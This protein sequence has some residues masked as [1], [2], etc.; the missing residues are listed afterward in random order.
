M[1]AKDQTPCKSMVDDGSPFAN[2]WKGS[3]AVLVVEDIEL[4]VHTQ[5][6]SL[7]SPVFEAMFNGN[8]V[9]AQTRRVPL[10]GKSYETV[11]HMLKLVY[12]LTNRLEPKTLACLSCKLGETKCKKDKKGRRKSYFNGCYLCGLYYKKNDLE[13]RLFIQHL[14]LLDEL[15]KEYMLDVLAD[16]IQAEIVHQSKAIANLQHAFDLLEASEKIADCMETAATSI[17]YIRLHLDSYGGL[18]DLLNERSLTIETIL[19]MKSIVLIN[20]LEKW[21][22]SNLFEH[23]GNQYKKEAMLLAKELFD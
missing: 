18:K 5:T 1:L 21:P 17:K 22:E 16:K 14:V 11:E 4:H 19:K 20:L 13:R 8:F 9:E 6:L 23:E 10:E 15:S 7:A 12:N 2:P 3:N